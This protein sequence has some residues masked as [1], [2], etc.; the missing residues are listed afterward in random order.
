MIF[1]FYSYKGGVGR[2]MALANIA[3]L[4]YKEGWNVLVVDWDLEAPGIERF[5][6]QDTQDNDSQNMAS[7]LEKPGVI[8]LLL[9]YKERMSMDLGEESPLNI[10]T[11]NIQEVY[12][13]TS[14]TNHL[15]IL[16]AGKRAGSTFVDY[17][18]NVLSFDWEDFYKNWEGRFFFK[19]LRDQFEAQYDVILIDSRT[20]VTEMGGVCTYELADAVVMFCTTN[21]QNISGTYEMALNFNSPKLH[22]LRPERPMKILILPARIEQTAEK[23][24]LIEFRNQF[25]ETFDEF[26][27]TIPGTTL[28]SY[29]E[30]RIP[31]APYYAFNEVVV[32][33]QEREHLEYFVEAFKTL[34]YQI[35]SI[36]MRSSEKN[37]HGSRIEIG[38]ATA[39]LPKKIVPVKKL[40]PTIIIGLGGTGVISVTFLK[41]ILQEQCPDSMPFVRFL[42]IDIDEPKGEVRS[43]RLFGEPIR[44][45][46]EKNEFFRITDQTRGDSARNIPA[47]A[48]WF[49][50]EGYKYLPLAEGARQAKPIGRLG[51]F[52][53]HP[54]IARRIYRLSDRL[55]TPNILQQFPFIRVGELNIYIVCSL[56]GGT[57]AGLFLDTAYEIRYLQQ[58]AQLPMRS[59]I[60]GL[61]ALG[62]L[63]DAISSRILANSYASLRECNWAQKEH[64]TYIPSY[65]DG[66]REA[67]SGRAFDSIYLFGDS[68]KSDI[69]LSSPQDFAQ[70]CSEF[71]LLDSGVGTAIEDM[72]DPLSAMMQSNRNNSEI[73]TLS[74]DADGT[75][76]CYSSFGLCKI[77]FPADRVAELCATRM[78]QAIIS[79]DIISSLQQ[80][81]I[82]EAQRMA[83]DF[84]VSERLICS[85]NNNFYLPD[86]LIRKHFETGEK[87]LLVE[88]ITKAL[89]AAYNNDVENIKQLE[90]GRITTVVQKL[91][92]ELNHFQND[93]PDHIIIELQNFQQLLDPKIQELFQEKRGIPFVITFLEELIESVK[94]SEEYTMI[95]LREFAEHD[96]RL[97]D[98]MNRQV[99]E[100]GYLLGGGFFD[101]LKKQAKS[102]QLKDTYK[103]IRQ[104]YVN[105]INIMRMRVAAN[106]YNGIYDAKQ[107]LMDDGE[108]VLLLLSNR[109]KT[110]HFMQQFF[111]NMTET[112]E[113]MY[114]NNK[115]I[116]CAPFEILIYN[117]EKFSMLDE[118]FET[119]YNDELRGKLFESILEQLGGNIW[120]FQNYMTEDNSQLYDIFMAVCAVEFQ[121]H[122]DQQTVAQRIIAAKKNR[123]HPTD[124]RPILQNAY[125]MSD[126]LC[127]LDDAVSRFADLRSSEQS[128][129]A[130]LAYIDKDDDAWRQIESIFRES[131]GRGG[132]R[133]PFTHTADPHT[134]IVYREFC[135][136]PAYAIK[137]IQAYHNNYVSEARRENTP[138]LQ[139]L[140]KEMLEFISVPS[141]PV[142]SKFDVMVV[143]AL[144]LGVIISD[145]ENYYMVTPEEWKRRTLA[146]EAQSKGDVVPIEERIVGNHRKLGSK[147][148]EVI[149]AMNRAIPT[150][151]LVS[152]NFSKWEEQIQQQI[153]QIRRRLSQERDLLC[154]LYEVMYFEGYQGTKLEVIN[155]EAEIRPA[156]V[157]ILMK[158]FA[159]KE[160]HIFRP[161]YT[162][163]E[164]LYHVYISSEDTPSK[165]KKG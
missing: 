135:G 157:F 113:E 22:R 74:Y 83:R 133:I 51:F 147:L 136:F 131:I 158:D 98:E 141:V 39:S 76:R 91:N 155:M 21:Q 80:A 41:K 138:P 86:R 71:I 145:E 27:A 32:V 50:D 24:E 114:E 132:W 123:D 149:A 101:F 5:F 139:M 93:I 154:D 38:R 134:I 96:K 127:R 12:R 112:F 44:L 104:Y 107:Q 108:G 1:T 125:E 70:L 29:W 137:R 11:L 58:Q 140:T 73:Y 53:A 52:L 7:I 48:S 106:F 67:I 46:P 89:A 35:S 16:T 65:P 26:L 142:L 56:C 117:N 159:I 115:R 152:S 69:A 124:Y 110:L 84:V 18:R 17:A 130:V 144:A 63:Y 59:R 36:L 88:W 128:T 100:M 9:K 20:G 121:K 34:A 33:R 10:T 150:E 43:N 148:T 94:K 90:I 61:F 55:V 143:E 122:L 111:S 3:E 75:P 160:T 116:K 49:P 19:W 99:R 23:D 95:E 119:I 105:R 153:D 37:P 60:K 109:L 31:Y 30:L 78:S 156:I 92:E 54:E 77:Y 13:N 72:G 87:L 81:E 2:S 82:I 120:N 66:T 162:H 4:L 68:N 146:I 165:S 62:D 64:A 163:Q 8:D 126:Y 28:K 118:E 42:A 47:V 15:D 6:F 97:S 164:L 25:Q 57:G 103:S 85:D 40:Q 14:T 161:K 102:A 151:A 79:H 129:V 45:D